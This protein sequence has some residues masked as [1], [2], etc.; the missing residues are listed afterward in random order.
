[1]QNN[2]LERYSAKLLFQFRIVIDNE[3]NKKRTCEERIIVIQEQSAKDA[4]KMAR[5][6]GKDAEYSYLNDDGNNVYFEFVGVMD[7]MHLGIESDN[8][9]VWYEI[10]KYL[11]PM[12]RKQKM[13]PPEGSLSAFKNE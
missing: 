8:D 3:S 13:I 12:E 9:E 11:M 6:R 5:E 10:K 2:K 4:L 7:L 1:M